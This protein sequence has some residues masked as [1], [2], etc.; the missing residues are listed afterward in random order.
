LSS[1]PTLPEET[2]VDN[3]NVNIVDQQNSKVCQT[4]SEVSAQADILSSLLGQ[5]STTTADSINR[6]KSFSNTNIESEIK[7]NLVENIVQNQPQ[8]NNELDLQFKSEPIQALQPKQPLQSLQSLQS[9]P[10]ISVNVN[11]IQGPSYT[12]FRPSGPQ[13]DVPLQQS[14][15]PVHSIHTDRASLSYD[16]AQQPNNTNSFSS[17]N[18]CDVSQNFN[19]NNSPFKQKYVN[20]GSPEANSEKFIVP[21][22]AP[23]KQRSRSRSISSPHINKDNN[24]PQALTLIPPQAA[25]SLTDI[26]SIRPIHN[27][28]RST[29]LPVYTHER[30][31]SVPSMHKNNINNSNFSSVNILYP[32]QQ[33]LQPNS[34][35][36]MSGQMNAEPNS[37]PSVTSFPSHQL[38]LSNAYNISQGSSGSTLIARLLTSNSSNNISN[39][40]QQLYSSNQSAASVVNASNSPNNRSTTIDAS[41]I[42]IRVPVTTI[43]NEKSQFLFSTEFK[44]ANIS[45]I[46]G[47]L[48]QNI[49]H[50]FVLQSTSD[51]HSPTT[52]IHQM[53]SPVKSRSSPVAT[54]SNDGFTAIPSPPQ[55]KVVKSKTNEERNQYKE[56]RRVCH[57]NAEQKRRCNI[58]N[59]FDTLRNLLPSLSQNTN[60]KISKAAMLQKAAEYIRALKNDRQTQQ[61]EYDLLRHQVESLNQTI[62][63][64]Q[65]QLPATGAPISCQRSSQSRELYENYVKRRTLENWKFWIFSIIMDSLVESYNSTVATSNVD[66]MCKT[67]LRWLDQNCC[68]ITLRRDVLNSLRFLSTSTNILTNPLSLPEEAVLAV[69]KKEKPSKS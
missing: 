26:H 69:T 6:L 55:L 4:I 27:V 34:K 61:E 47:Q 67:L 15:S 63:V 31:R 32:S 25:I 12:Q 50:N 35:L 3:T 1:L 24:A 49:K 37:V 60:T 30:K 68:L 7:Q 64:F 58:K 66:E 33:Q 13:R 8:M 19:V 43:G 41:S 52:Q 42:G 36:Q 65:N 56:H 38:V 2:T 28:E 14:Q 21:K 51:I 57:I 59:G 46:A 62:G 48:N 39:L 44:D 40:S 29:S 11:Q 16:F 17:F 18:L 20:A 45:S 53:P 5:T 23:I 10:V 22:S 9:M 54:S